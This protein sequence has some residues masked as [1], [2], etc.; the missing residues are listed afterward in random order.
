M[1]IDS[2]ILSRSKKIVIIQLL[3]KANTHKKDK[4]L[5]QSFKFGN[6][7]PLML[8]LPLLCLAYPKKK[9]PPPPNNSYIYKINI[10]F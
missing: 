7:K 8:P 9:N 4:H 10:L 2:K 3:N 6:R 1:D 5:P